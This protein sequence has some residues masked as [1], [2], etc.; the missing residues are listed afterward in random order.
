MVT[1]LQVRNIRC[2]DGLHYSFELLEHF[3]KALHATCCEILHDNSKVIPALACCWGFVDTLHRI[4]EIGQSI[5]GLSAKHQEMRAFLSE[6]ALAEDY[7]HYIQHLRIELSK[8]PPNT[9][10]VW[11]SLSWVDGSSDERSYVAIFGAYLSGT[12]YTGCVYDTVNRVWVSKVCLG[13]DH[14]SFNFDPIYEAALRFK[15]FV[16]P[17]LIK[18][19]SEAIKFH[20]NLPII[21]IDIEVR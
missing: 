19:N 6:T 3:H 16:M 21:T 12:S 14:R 1:K 9:F 5:P 15:K 10:P 4:R 20:N 7:R 8:D 17:F 11:G 13:V 2:L 18:G